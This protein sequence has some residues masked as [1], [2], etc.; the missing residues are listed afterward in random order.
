MNQKEQQRLERLLMQRIKQYKP[1][2]DSMLQRMSGH[3]TYEGL[4][5]LGRLPGTRTQS[6]RGC[7]RQYVP[8][9]CDRFGK[10]LQVV[11]AKESCGG[12]GVSWQWNPG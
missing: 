7:S 10:R 9:P 1:Y 8:V 5:V 4:F 11:L 2:L 3:W 12:H 6:L